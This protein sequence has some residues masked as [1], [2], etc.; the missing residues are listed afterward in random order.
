M[1]IKVPC[2]QLDT[3]ITCDPA[4]SEKVSACRTAIVCVSMS[5]YSKIFLRDYW[6]GRQGDPYRV[7]QSI[8]NM[9]HEY[10]PRAIGIESIGYQQALMPFMQREMNSRG[11]F[12]QVIPLKP[13]RNEKKEMRILSV[14]PYF[15]SGQ[16]F[17][18]RGAMEF[19]EE[20][21]TFPNGKTVD[22]LDAFSYA[23]RMLVAL[24]A[25]RK[26]AVEEK[27]DHM[28]LTDPNGA[29]YWRGVQRKWGNLPLEE[30]ELDEV[31]VEEGVGI[32]DFIN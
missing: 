15:R 12:H 11:E 29:R 26:P 27:L 32:G 22:I 4:I 18:P 1:I 6:V 24:V 21:E 9:A 2:N 20:Y 28:A 23:V 16:I 25:H 8:L 7:V 13:D 31:G 5:P 10:Q 19:I 30:D 14:Q 3:V 17:I